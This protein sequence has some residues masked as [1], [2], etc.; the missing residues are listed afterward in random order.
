MYKNYMENEKAHSEN[1]IKAELFEYY[2]QES[3]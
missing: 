3:K 2:Q 1:D